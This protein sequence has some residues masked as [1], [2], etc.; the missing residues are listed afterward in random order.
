MRI[1]AWR[2]QLV[3]VVRMLDGADP[4]AAF[5]QLLDQL[6]DQSGLAMVLSSNDVQSTH[7]V[8]RGEKTE[9]EGVL[10]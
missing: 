4:P 6:G 3:V 1:L 9:G 5:R 10:G 2:V 8:V 7:A